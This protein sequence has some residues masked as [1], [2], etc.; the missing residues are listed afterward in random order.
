[1]EIG[2]VNYHNKF[3]ILKT[4]NTR[5]SINRIKTTLSSKRIGANRVIQ[6]IIEIC[7]IIVAI[8]SIIE[9]MDIVIN[10][11]FEPIRYLRPAPIT[12]PAR[13]ISNL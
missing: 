5:T 9:S 11:L 8:L 2:I 7:K 1:M 3:M 4:Y 13:L 6:V 10:E 12:N